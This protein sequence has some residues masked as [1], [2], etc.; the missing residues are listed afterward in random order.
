M[1]LDFMNNLVQDQELYYTYM[2]Y[3][4][5]EHK[6]NS[7]MISHSWKKCSHDDSI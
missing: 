4:A 7:S 3:L 1:L 2:S 5:I 6:P